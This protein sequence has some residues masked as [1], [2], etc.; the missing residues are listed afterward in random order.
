ML[1]FLEPSRSTPVFAFAP[2]E[3]CA[4]GHVA[5]MYSRIGLQPD[6]FVAPTPEGFAGAAIKFASAGVEGQRRF[7]D[8]VRARAK[9]RLFG[10]GDAVHE[11]A[12]LIRQAVAAI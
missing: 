9:E 12:D 5:G 2:P 4:G 10:N 8:L 3:T 1:V 7:R 6:I 11:W